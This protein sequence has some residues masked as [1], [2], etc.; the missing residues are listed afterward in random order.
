[1]LLLL[2]FVLSLQPH[3]SLLRKR[4]ERPKLRFHSAMESPQQQQKQQQE[5]R[6]R[7]TLLLLLLHHQKGKTPQGSPV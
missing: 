3:I 2:F 5:Q 6:Q 1:M 7:Q 4:K